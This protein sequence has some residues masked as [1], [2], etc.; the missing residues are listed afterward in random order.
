ML[1]RVSWCGPVKIELTVA[2][3]EEVDLVASMV[4]GALPGHTSEERR[5]GQRD[6]NKSGVD[7][8]F[9]RGQPTIASWGCE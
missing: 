7:F 4:A 8:H 6:H 1:P 2:R 5:V 3:E 9:G